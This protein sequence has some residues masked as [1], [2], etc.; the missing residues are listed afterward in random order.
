MGRRRVSMDDQ[1]MEREPT[2]WIPVPGPLLAY[3]GGPRRP[4]SAHRPR[5]GFS[6]RRLTRAA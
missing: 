5:R 1:T 6:F 4:M 2:S 3:P